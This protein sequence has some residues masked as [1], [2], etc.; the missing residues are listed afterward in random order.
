MSQ[1]ETKCKMF[2]NCTVYDDPKNCTTACDHYNPKNPDEELNL[3]EVEMPDEIIGTSPEIPDVRLM[4]SDLQKFDK[5]FEFAVL[6]KHVFTFQ[7]ISPKKIILKYRRKLKNTDG[8]HDGCYIFRGKEDELL[9]PLKTFKFLDE[10]A[11]EKA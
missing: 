4:F 2:G 10:R 11:K 5:N 9:E 3:E 1:G 7:S 8:L 6:K